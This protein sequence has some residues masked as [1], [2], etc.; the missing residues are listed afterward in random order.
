[1]LTSE[2]QAKIKA[3]IASVPQLA[4]RP[5]TP[6]DCDAIAKVLNRRSDPAVMLWR[7]DV[8][9][10]EIKAATDWA[11][12]MTMTPLQQNT[13]S[14]LISG[15]L[16]ATQASLR[17][18]LASVLPMAPNTRNGISAIARRA[19]TRGEAVLVEGM[20]DPAI[21][22]VRLTSTDIMEVRTT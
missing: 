16:D 6:D 12:I 22:P 15:G 9:Y 4:E 5:V 19:A 21:D 10:A 1:M 7:S 11:E 14:M 2:E 3:H 18:A 17:A 8:T 20:A 13:F